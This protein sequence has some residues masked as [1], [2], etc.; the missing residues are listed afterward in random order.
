MANDKSQAVELTPTNGGKIKWEQGKVSV[1]MGRDSVFKCI[2]IDCFVQIES[3]MLLIVLFYMQNS[4][5]EQK[6]GDEISL[7]ISL[8]IK[9]KY[10]WAFCYKRNSKRILENTWNT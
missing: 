6:S 1:N 7:R 9:W 3:E 10:W 5:S 4:T 8:R 2:N